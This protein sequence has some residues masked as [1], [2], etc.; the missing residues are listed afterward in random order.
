MDALRNSSVLDD[1]TGTIFLSQ[2]EAFAK[3]INNQYAL[4]MSPDNKDP[5]L[6]RGL[7]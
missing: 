2:N 6:A 5:W 4:N 1:M 7:I 3:L